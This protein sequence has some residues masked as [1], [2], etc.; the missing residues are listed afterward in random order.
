ME[1]KQPTREHRAYLRVT[2]PARVVIDGCNYTVNNW[3]IGGICIGDFSQTTLVGECLPIQLS[4]SFKGGINI[5]TNTLI[6]VVW[7]SSNQK[8]IRERFLNLT[9]IKCELNLK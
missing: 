9:R 8:K 7:I 3:S 2:A 6:E 4:L 5:S 1:V